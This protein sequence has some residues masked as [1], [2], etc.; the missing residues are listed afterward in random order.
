[1]SHPVVPAMDRRRFLGA[2][3]AATLGGCAPAVRKERPPNVLFVLPDQLRAQ[4]V[5]YMGNTEVK[6]PHIDQ[7]AADGLVFE[8]TVANTPVCC[9]ARAILMT[10]QYCHKNGMVANDLRLNE[11]HQ[12]IAKVFQA[13]G[14][15][16]GFVGKWHLDGGPRMPGFVPPGPRRQGFEFW[17]ANQCS[18]RHF[19]TQY[20]RDSE[21]PI[22]ANGKFES[23]LWGEL[24]LEFLEGVKR[25]ERPFFLSVFSGP[26][27]DPYKA[28]EEYERMY[29]PER[30]TL[31]PNWKAGERVPDRKAIASY[32]AMTTS[33]DDQ[34]GMLLKGLDDLGLREDTIVLFS[35]D[36]GDMLGSQ[37]M[38]LKRKPWEESIRVPG[39][40]RYPKGIRAGDRETAPF[41]LVDVA[42][43]LLSLCGLQPPAA[44][45]GQDFSRRILG[46]AQELPDSAFFQIFGPFLAGRVTEGW[47]GVR[48]NRYMYARYESRPWVLYDLQ[49]DPY[50]MNNLAEDAA[51]ASIRQDMEA[52]LQAWMTR[53][54]DSWSYNWTVPVED[55]GRLYKERM[56]R[57]VQE[58]LAEHPQG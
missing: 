14:Y 23:Q 1:M 34:L 19:D 8:N 33:I 35:S 47:R 30:I 13:G 12:S 6:T 9:P 22:P 7:L 58:Y 31:R 51:A 37:G 28:P 11:D 42:P 52:R 3:A 10:G 27:H 5:G 36:H 29:D 39:V 16:T 38:P 21:D 56:Y 55:A 43:T 44:M 50:Q 26:P 41:S 45:Q 24:G 46:R 25:D 17:A 48:T 18:H 4:S 2:A 49:E 40:L 20:F 15:R 57:T 54:N 53:T 32:Y